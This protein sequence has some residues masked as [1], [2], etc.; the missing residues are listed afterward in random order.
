[1]PAANGAHIPLEHLANIRYTI[2]PQEIKSENTLLVG[3]VTMMAV[4]MITLF[5]VPWI[6]CWVEEVKLR[7]RLAREPA[8]GADAGRPGA[9]PPPGEPGGPAPAANT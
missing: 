6:Y 4:S 9:D 3:Y 5:V 1:M 7:R 8:S 2:G